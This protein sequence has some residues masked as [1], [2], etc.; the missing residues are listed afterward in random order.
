M[1]QIILKSVHQCRCSTA[2]LVEQ[3]RTRSLVDNKIE[4]L[5]CDAEQP[6]VYSFD[7]PAT[8]IIFSK[9]EDEVR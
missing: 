6:L 4:V 3:L 1:A 2:N 8:V 5:D 7:R 9:T